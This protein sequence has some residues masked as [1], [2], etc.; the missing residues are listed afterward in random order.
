MSDRVERCRYLF[1]SRSKSKCN[2]IYMFM[3]TYKTIEEKKQYLQ[4]QKIMTSE[5]LWAFID[6]C[7]GNKNL[8]FRG[9]NEAQYMSFSSAQVR[10]NASLDQQSYVKIISEAISE[11][12]KSTLLMNYIRK[13]SL[14]ESDFQI[15]ALLQHYG[16]GTPILDY[17]TNIDSALFFATDRQGKEIQNYPKD[18]ESIDAFISI[19]Y[20]DKRDPNHCSVQEFSAR[21]SEKINELDAKLAKEYGSIYEGI[22]EQTKKSLEQLPFDEMAQFKYGGLFAVLGHSNG[23][24]HYKVGDKDVEYNIDN[25]RVKAQEGMFLFNGLSKVPYEKAAHDWYSGIEN[26]CVD[27]HKSLEGEIIR[28]LEKKGVTCCSIYPQ[29]KESKAIIEEVK[30]LNIDERLKHKPVVCK[31]RCWIVAVWNWL[32]RIMN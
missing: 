14:D 23:I 6:E 20:F 5:E 30:R 9:V 1:G 15:L 19:Y 26:C 22:S 24:I 11:V 8:V 4:T 16:C 28:Y 13:Y 7:K 29:T 21:D 25:E 27:I 3:C 18:D 12:R 17:S 32:K 10:T 2:L 31:K